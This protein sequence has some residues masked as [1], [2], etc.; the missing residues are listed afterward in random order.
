MKIPLRVMISPVGRPDVYKS[1]A[2]A[3]EFMSRLLA[4][5]TAK[6]IANECRVEVV[7]YTPLHESKLHRAMGFSHTAENFYMFSC[8]EQD[9]GGKA[10]KVQTFDCLAGKNGAAEF[11]G[12]VARSWKESGGEKTEEVAGIHIL[13]QNGLPIK[14]LWIEAER[15]ST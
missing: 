1:L 10:R 2:C 9:R 14:K 7:G 4:S 3:E 12:N 8:W 13:Y 11:N 6:E 15:R 5:E